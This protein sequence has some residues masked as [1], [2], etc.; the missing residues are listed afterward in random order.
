[1]AGKGA[2]A[3]QEPA[4]SLTVADAR[5]LVQT[6]EAR[7]KGARQ[8]PFAAPAGK[9][10]APFE[11]GDPFGLRKGVFPVFERS[12]LGDLVGLGT[13]FHVD[14]WGGCLTAEHVV[15]F[16]RAGLPDAGLMG[17]RSHEVDPK[18]HNHAVALLGIGLVFGELAVPEWAFAPIVSASLVSRERNDPLAAL[19][20]RERLGIPS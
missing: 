20:G 8:I 18:Q 19:Q 9:P 4:D 14:G 3:A 12:P 11:V 10:A 7:A 5:F 13:A 17:G 6:C 16:L 15:E 2:L 1:M